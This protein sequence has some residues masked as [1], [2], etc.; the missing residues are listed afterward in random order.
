MPKAQ[1]Y[2]S[3]EQTNSF[4]PSG[5]VQYLVR[6]W[7]DNLVVSCYYDRGKTFFACSDF[8]GFFSPYN[9]A[10]FTTPANYSDAIPSGY[11]V[12]DMKISIALLP[13]ALQ[14]MRL[15]LRMFIQALADS[16]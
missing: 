12:R 7:K 2:N 10:G 5:S 8:G 1:S 4:M 11:F 3:A 16:F 15:P 9:P 6:E 14:A 13:P